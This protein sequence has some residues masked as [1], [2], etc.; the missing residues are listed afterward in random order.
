MPLDP[1]VLSAALSAAPETGGV[2]IPLTLLLAF[3]PALFGQ[4][5]GQRDMNELIKYLK[6][7]Q[8][9]YMSPNLPQVDAA[10]LK[11]VMNQLGRTNQGWG[12]P[13]GE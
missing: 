12:W 3:L 6:P 10:S 11:A 8:P 4:N 7:S 13:G 2:S 1:S 5:R 9:M